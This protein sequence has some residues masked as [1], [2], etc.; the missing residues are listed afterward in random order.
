MSFLSSAGLFKITDTEKRERIDGEKSILAKLDDEAFA[1]KEMLDKE[2][3]ERI[4]AVK[5]LRNHT[6]F[7][8]KS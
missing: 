3:T 6:D 1:L 8:L 4:L 7:E 2:K 5:E